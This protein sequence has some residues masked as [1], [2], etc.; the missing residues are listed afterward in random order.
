[1]ENT[2][3]N[4]EKF[5][6][7]YW[8]QEVAIQ[9]EGGGTGFRY[10]INEATITDIKSDYLLL[11]PLSMIS[12]EDA[13]QVGMLHDV[14]H[15]KNTLIIGKA[16]IHWLNVNSKSR[17]LNIEIIDFLRSKGYAL[18]FMGLSVEQQIEY[19]WVKLTLKK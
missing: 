18:P 11:T 13:L 8:G 10:D 12:D 3:H 7:Q 9:N 17:D 4:K 15:L 6:A 14:P 5:F 19:G 2:I 16:I 1:M